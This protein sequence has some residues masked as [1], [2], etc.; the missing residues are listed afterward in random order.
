MTDA[1]SADW[2]SI[3][4]TA[5]GAI[6]SGNVRRDTSAL[7]RPTLVALDDAGEL[8]WATEIDPGAGS[9]DATIVEVVKT[10]SGELLAVGK[11]DYELPDRSIDQWNALIMRL[12]PDGTP[13]ASFV[14]GG[15][16][17]D[18]VT[19]VAVQPD[20]SYAISGQTLVTPR[21]STESWVAS[22]DPDDNLLWSSTYADRLDAGYA[23]ATGIT[24]VPGGDYVV[25]GT[26][27]MTDK[28]GWMIRLD[29]S[30]MPMW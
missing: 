25:S 12:N 6:I 29:R 11:V 5:D 27:G 1:T 15:P 21:A 20:G 7:D 18:I 30:G 26:T 14:F 4:P 10:P 3:T 19:G 17:L 28:D 9:G 23:T 13:V 8:Q 24:A 22:F 2:S 16:Y